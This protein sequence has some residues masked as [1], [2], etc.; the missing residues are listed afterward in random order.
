[1]EFLAYIPV[2]ILLIIGIAANVG[3]GVINR[4]YTKSV[5]NGMGGFYLFLMITSYVSAGLWRSFK[6]L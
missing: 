4:Y 1:M 5:S 6:A 3:S 2:P